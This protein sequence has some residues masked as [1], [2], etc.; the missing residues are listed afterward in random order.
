MSCPEF[1]HSPRGRQGLGVIQPQSGLDYPL[2]S[3]SADIRYLIADM[4]FAYDDPA[5]YLSDEQ[6]VVHPLKITWL[7]GVGCE[8][9][10]AISGMPLPTHA[11][12]ILI[13]DTN[14]N[15][16]FDSTDLGG[17]DET[18]QQFATRNWGA[19]YKIYEWTSPKAVCR[20]VVYKTWG[21]DEQNPVNYPTNL[22][23]E[24]A[25][26]DER[27]VYKMPKRLKSLSVLTATAKRTPVIFKAGYNMRLTPEPQEI[28]GLRNQTTIDFSVVEGAGFGQYSDC[29]D[30]KPKYIYTINGV[31]P[32]QY[33]DFFIA[34]TDCLYGRVA[35][36]D[37]GDGLVAPLEATGITVGADCPPCCDCPD[38][39]ATA[40]Y[41][42]R[43]RDQYARIGQRTREVK[44]LH[45]N[46][47]DRWVAQR[48]CR[49]R[50]PL[51]ISLAPLSCPYMEVIMQFCNQCPECV[52][53]VVL[54][55]TLESFPGGAVG[56]IVPGYAIINA[57]GAPNEPFHITGGWPTFNARIGF[58]DK[59]AS[60]FVRFLLK[61]SPKNYAYSI[62]G[63]LTGTIGAA[64]I[65]PCDPAIENTEISSSVDT[66]ALYCN[67]NGCTDIFTLATDIIILATNI[68]ID[69]SNN[70]IYTVNAATNTGVAV[71]YRWQYTDD[72]GINWELLQNEDLAVTGSQTATLTLLETYTLQY[73]NRN[74][75]VVLSAD[76]ATTRTYSFITP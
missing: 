2:V 36:A 35:T 75:R 13:T 60:A 66:H 51:R 12:D 39:V 34:A 56:S 74:Y 31:G 52:E 32:N 65:T 76:K 16:V 10:P 9:S 57:P 49:V 54:S 43:T 21:P 42:N 4:Y 11:A 19:D 64:P 7:Y 5:L 15:V 67:R 38:Y 68:A 45:E 23:P 8:E 28:V 24:N 29:Q 1:T 33:G 37:N 22:A 73:P 70:T 30:D 20:L 44:L 48:E 3:P 62:T 50:K 58:V 46:N 63:T 53:D 61:F 25:A 69:E 47:I 26:I 71:V 72:T 6:P 18:Y 55:A 40:Q 14:D 27:A 17:E 59:G 41:M